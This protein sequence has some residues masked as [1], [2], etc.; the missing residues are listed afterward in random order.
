MVV[1]F[2]GSQGL[3]GGTERACAD[4]ASTLSDLG[5]PVTILS[6]YGGR[7]SHYEVSEPVILDELSCER[8]RGVVGY[9]S[10][11]WLLLRYVIKT[12]PHAVV[13][14]ESISFL[15]L[16]PLLLLS[17]RPVLVNWEHFNANVDLGV[18]ARNYSRKLAARFADKIVVL[19]QR[20]VQIWKRKF[21]SSENK[22]E[23]IYNINPFS[24]LGNNDA[25]KKASR[26]GLKRVVSAGRLTHQKGFDLLLQAW[27]KIDH[28]VRDGWELVI[29]GEGEDRESLEHAISSHSLDNVFLPGQS[30]QIED[31]FFASDIFVLPSRF[32]GFGLVVLEAL[33]C[34]L[35]VV[36]F[37]C[38]AGPAEIVEDAVNG[39]I[40]PAGNVDELSVA[41]AS[42]MSSDE[43]REEMSK[44]S[45][46]SVSKFD[47]EEISKRWVKLFRGLGVNA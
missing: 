37:D 24:G 31:D 40:V 44:A 9:L 41:L 42:L 20:D 16:I 8:R 26:C 23:V 36:S 21:P 38:D 4:T 34:G 33:S 39:L 29:L 35:P 5:Y 19:S 7:V 12:R 11:S 15:F 46:V 32:E 43:V 10:S 6:Q 27:A 25:K 3:K 45:H 22:L 30:D 28:P 1:F 14:V 17:S 47:D 2:T 18:K 13:A